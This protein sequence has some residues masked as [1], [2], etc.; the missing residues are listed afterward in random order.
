VLVNPA[1]QVAEAKLA[2]AARPMGQLG[3]G[4]GAARRFTGKGM[5]GGV[6]VGVL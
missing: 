5:F 3:V 6:G 1:A 4:A 2:V